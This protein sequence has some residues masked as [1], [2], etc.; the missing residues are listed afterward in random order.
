MQEDDVQ[1]ATFYAQEYDSLKRTCLMDSDLPQIK[2]IPDKV[3][4]QAKLDMTTLDQF[5]KGMESIQVC[6]ENF[7]G[8]APDS[9]PSRQTLTT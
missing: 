1:L 9:L 4:F 7:Q 8:A 3:N 6:L 5:L 2:D